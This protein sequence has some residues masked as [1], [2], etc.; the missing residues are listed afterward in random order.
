MR[1]QLLAATALSTTLGSLL[2]AAAYAQ[3]AFNWSGPY[4]GGSIGIAA[5]GGSTDLSYPAPGVSSLGTGFEFGGGGLLYDG[6]PGDGDAGP[7]P[8]TFGLDTRGGLVVVNAGY[9]LQSGQFVYGIEGDYGLLN[10]ASHRSGT[11]PSGDTTVTSDT[12]LSSLMSLRARAGIVADRLMFFAT[13][14]LAAGQTALD[15]NLTFDNGK[16]HANAAGHASGLQPGFIAGGGLE[17][18]ATDHLTLKAQVLYYNLEPLSATATGSGFVD[19]ASTST[20]QPYAA[21]YKPSGLLIE[22]GINV[23]F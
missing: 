13:A 2:P 12:S 8:A 19:P 20:L 7:L 11:T 1:V 9:N 22:T 10:G 18:A 4:A 6:L 15:T 14:G 23:K 16:H 5:A 3:H 17:F 21:T